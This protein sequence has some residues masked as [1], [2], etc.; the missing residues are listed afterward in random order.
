MKPGREKTRGRGNQLVFRI[1]AE[2]P[3]KGNEVPDFLPREGV[4]VTGWFTEGG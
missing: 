3:G 2:Y 4:G 1:Y